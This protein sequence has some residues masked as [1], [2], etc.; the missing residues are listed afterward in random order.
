M[1]LNISHCDYFYLD[2]H[3]V[4]LRGG[5]DVQGS[6][7]LDVA[8]RKF[9]NKISEIGRALVIKCCTENGPVQL[10]IIKCHFLTKSHYHNSQDILF[11][12]IITGKDCSIAPTESL[13]CRQ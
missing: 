1:A 5:G 10:N 2:G 13:A 9:W 7:A 4:L 3:T 8:H 6:L 12:G 11:H